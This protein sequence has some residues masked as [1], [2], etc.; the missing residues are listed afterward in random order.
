M[1]NKNHDVCVTCGQTMVDGLHTGYWNDLHVQ[2]YLDLII[3]LTNKF[4]AEHY[5][6]LKAPIF[7]IEKGRKYHR[8]VS[9]YD[10]G[11]RNV[12]AFIGTDG[13]LFK[14]ASWKAPAKD[15]RYDLNT[16]MEKIEQVFDPH[17]GY[18][19]KR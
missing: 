17:G 8:V 6:N 9:D 4:Y 5:P 15:A 18:L 12:H 16:D 7:Y 10:V 14:A 3:R 11:H 1:S 19:Y 13:K 2:A